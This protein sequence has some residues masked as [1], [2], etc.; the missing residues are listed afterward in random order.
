MKYKL[1]YDI[2]TEYGFVHIHAVPAD[3]SG[4]PRLTPYTRIATI[5]DPEHEVPGITI[6]RPLGINFVE[7]IIAD[8]KAK[9]HLNW[10]PST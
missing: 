6:D 1:V 7:Q 4:T 3:L 5:F 2:D 8:I 10:S 9:K